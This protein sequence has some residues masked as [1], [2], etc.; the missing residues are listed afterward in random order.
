M[1]TLAIILGGITGLGLVAPE[2]PPTVT[3]VTGIAI[4]ITYA[5]LCRVFASQRNR[6]PLPWAFLGLLTGVFAVF[7]LLLLGDGDRGEES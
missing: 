7:G 1:Q 6:A 3:V 5:V 2:L 4:Q